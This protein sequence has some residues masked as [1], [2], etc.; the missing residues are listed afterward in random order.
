MTDIVPFLLS[1]L[2]SPGLSGFE[3]PVSRLIAEKW[4]P[5]VDELT[6][7]PVG[8]LHGLRRAVNTKS[9][10]SIM[11]ATHMDAI[12]L[13]VKKIENGLLL[14]TEIGGVDP[15][16]LPGQWVTIHGKREVHGVLQLI[17]DRLLDSHASGN[18]PEFKTLFVDTGLKESELLKLVQVGDIISFGQ[19]PFEMDGGYVAGH[20]LD[21]RA[22]VA[23]LTICLEELRMF[24][25]AWNLWA[26][27]TSKEE[28]F[29]VGA[30]TSAFA[31]RPDIAVTIDVTFA[32]GPGSSDHRCFPL[33]KGPSIG[34]GGNIHPALQREFTKIAKEMD[35]PYAIETMP[36]SSGTDSM[37][38]Q[39]TAEGIPNEVL[40]IPLRYMHTSVELVSVNDILRAGRLLARF[41]SKLTPE[42][43]DGLYEEKPH[44][45]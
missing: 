36:K 13:I 35:M 42:S 31:I 32:K 27:A 10:P 24:N 9:A 14:F 16:I 17:P 15:R 22:S 21:N 19:T 6:T 44:D 20:S 5:L 29:G 33:G 11:I 45:K 7:T 25:L 30:S 39:V 4:R 43:L 26:V 18:S 3:E 28:E 40:G 41:I 1:L 37:V 34:L 23:A 12:G 8:S 38:I 2:E